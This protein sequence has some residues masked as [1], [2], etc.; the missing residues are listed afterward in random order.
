MR[1]SLAAVLTVLGAATVQA[2]DLPISLEITGSE[3]ARVTGTCVLM[4]SDGSERIMLDQAVPVSLTREGT[5]FSCKIE[6][7]GRVA[8]AAKRGSSKSNSKLNNGVATFRV[9]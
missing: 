5:S 6:A 1:S 7:K 4:H 8:I 9:E 3:G 2:Q